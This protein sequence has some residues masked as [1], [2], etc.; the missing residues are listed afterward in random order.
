[1]ILFP[2]ITFLNLMIFYTEKLIE[3]YVYMIN[4][5]I[6]KIS[7]DAAEEPTQLAAR[8]V[9]LQDHKGALEDDVILEIILD[10]AEK[11]ET[12]IGKTPEVDLPE[13]MGG[14][15]GIPRLLVPGLLVVVAIVMYVGNS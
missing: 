10:E 8:S 3:F 6:L 9:V 11:D 2:W 4:D 13:Q 5:V 1:M 15:L 7:T 14:T 12:E